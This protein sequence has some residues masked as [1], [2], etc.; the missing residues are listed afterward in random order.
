MLTS[1]FI[2]EAFKSLPAEPEPFSEWSINALFRACIEAAGV[3]PETPRSLA[4]F[5]AL[6]HDDGVISAIESLQETYDEGLDTTAER[7]ELLSRIE[8][9]IRDAD[10]AAA[11]DR[12]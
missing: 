8:G 9:A 11:G 2:T 7:D 3:R 10:V 12:C 6:W 1:S 5:E 4:L